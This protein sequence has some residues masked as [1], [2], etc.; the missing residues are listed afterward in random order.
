MDKLKKLEENLK[1]LGSVAVGYSGGVDSTFLLTVAH[2]VLGDKAVAVTGVDE[3]MP[4]RELEAAEKY[5]AEKGIRHLIVRTRPL[6]E[7]GY[8]FNSRDR[9]Y[10]CKRC[11]FTEMRKAADREGIKYIAEG[12]NTDDLG[13]YRPGLRAVAELDVV[14][15]LRDAGL[16]KEEIRCCSRE[17]GIPTWDKPA[18]ACLA[19]RFEYGQ[20]ITVEKLAM[21]EKAEQLLAELGF[22]Q[23]RVRVHGKLARIE[24]EP[25]DIERLARED[26][27]SVVWAALKGYGFDFVALDLKGYKTGSMNIG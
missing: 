8:R 11:L 21:V 5:C 4:A 18:F 2:R 23:M 9:C 22:R 13:D 12:S 24:V 16:T 19:S 26:T 3:S 14:S 20:E 10:Y 7:E 25:G 17:L 27:R 15:P 6:E 1:A